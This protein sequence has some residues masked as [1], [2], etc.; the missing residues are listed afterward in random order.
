[1]DILGDNLWLWFSPLLIFF[2]VGSM[3]RMKGEIH[4][5]IE[6]TQAVLCNKFN[7][8]QHSSRHPHRKNRKDNYYW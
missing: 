7:S 1:M 6:G 3:G 2:S 4:D 8:T 5:G